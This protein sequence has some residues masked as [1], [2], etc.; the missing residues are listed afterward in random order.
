MKHK[1][2]YLLLLLI[3][4][5]IALAE[6]VSNVRVRQQGE[7]IVITYDLAKMSDIAIYYSV[8]MSSNFFL[9]AQVSGDVG[10]N[11]TRGSNKTITWYPLKELK[12]GSFIYD[13]VRFKIEAVDRKTKHKQNP[14]YYGR[15]D[16]PDHYLEAMY[17]LKVPKLDHSVGLRYAW[18]PKRFGLEVAPMYGIANQELSVTMGPTFRLTR[19]SSPLSLQ[20]SLGGGA[21]YRFTDN[22]LTWAADASLRFGFGE[23]I[24]KFGWYSFGLGV[25]Y[26]DGNFIPNATLSFMPFRWIYLGIVEEEDFPHIYTEAQ[27]AYAFERKDWM[28]GGNVGYIPGH[29]GI[30]ASFLV[31]L[32]HHSWSVTGDVIF[33]LTPDDVFMDLQVYQGFGYAKL[34]SYG[35]GFAMETGIRLGF[36]EDLPY[37]G[38]WSL[39]VGCLYD[40]TGSPA[41]TFG[42]SLPIA[43]IAGTAGLGTPILLNV[44]Y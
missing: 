26:Q 18:I 10:E 9:L 29:I 38:L 13:D 44:I 42:V 21:M 1:I 2:T 14:W 30:G 6:N 22:H 40:L 16:H 43:F 7:T 33:R 12:K 19:F 4:P 36:G 35:G 8:N 5:L 39:N 20:L 23:D 17:G 41:I 32:L 11:I 31:G 3:L 34:N 25:R 15:D 28:L 27:A 24:S 37:F